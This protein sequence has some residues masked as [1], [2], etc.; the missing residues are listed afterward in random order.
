[1][2]DLHSTIYMIIY[3]YNTLPHIETHFNTFANRADPDQ[4]SLVKA[5]W[6]GSSQFAYE[7]MIRCDHTLVG[8]TSNFFVLCTNVKVYLYN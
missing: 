4:T 2:L 3:V 5:A 1:M 7:H 8:L 6:S